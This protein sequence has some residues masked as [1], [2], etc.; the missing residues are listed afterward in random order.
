MQKS[1][2]EVFSPKDL[3]GHWKQLTV[4]LGMVTGEVMLIVGFHPQNL[5][6]EE[7]STLKEEIKE[8]YKSGSGSEFHVDSLHFQI[9][10]R[11]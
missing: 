1:Q 8:F 6:D 2:F 3:S 9:M 10:K 11:K 7:L 5:N 4:R